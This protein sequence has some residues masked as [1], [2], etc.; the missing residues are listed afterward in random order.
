M[1]SLGNFAIVQRLK[2][3]KIYGRMQKQDLD[4]WFGSSGSREFFRF[5]YYDAKA[6]F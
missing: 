6:R 3:A 5:Y 1:P 2:K 4:K